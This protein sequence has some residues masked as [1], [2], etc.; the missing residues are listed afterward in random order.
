MVATKKWNWVILIGAGA[1]ALM[2]GLVIFNKPPSPAKPAPE[3]ARKH[4]AKTKSAPNTTPFGS[5]RAAETDPNHDQEK[6]PCMMFITSTGGQNIAVKVVSSK[7]DWKGDGNG[8]FQGTTVSF[9]W[10]GPKDSSGTAEFT[11]N[12]DGT[13]FTG[14]YTRWDSKETFHGM[15]HRIQ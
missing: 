12:P 6:N 10:K 9:K 8:T 7:G 3:H 5:W 15:G 14:T 2:I 13:G 4:D 11:I 1:A